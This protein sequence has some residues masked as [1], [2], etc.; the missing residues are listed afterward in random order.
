VVVGSNDNGQAMTD[1]QHIE[2]NAPGF[3]STWFL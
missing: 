1:I 3:R 2:G